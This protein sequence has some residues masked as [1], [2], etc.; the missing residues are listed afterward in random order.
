[1]SARRVCAGAL[2]CVAIV[3]GAA[4]GP[5]GSTRAEDP[6]ECW[7]L[8]TFR[9]CSQTPGFR[10]FCSPVWCEGKVV[11]DNLITQ[12]V[13]PV[14]QGWDP[15]IL[16]GSSRK[17]EFFPAFCDYGVEPPCNW[18]TSTTVV[19]HVVDLDPGIPFNCP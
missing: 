1:M 3:G 6:P 15:P 11:E 12:A 10:I 16:S 9:A 4:L 7:T 14:A 18:L 2:I 19:W 8:T 5:S 17:C 13:E